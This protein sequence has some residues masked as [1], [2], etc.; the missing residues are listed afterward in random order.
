MEFMAHL[1]S[2]IPSPYESLVYYYGIYSS[3]HRGKEKR[4]NADKEELKTKEVQG[5]TGTVDG[6]ITSTW[7]RL[8]R[9]IFEVNPLCCKKCGGEMKIVAFITNTNRIS[10]F[11]IPCSIILIR[12]FCF[13][14]KI[15]RTFC[16][17]F[18]SFCEISSEHNKINKA[19]SD[20]P[21]LS[22]KFFIV[23]FGNKN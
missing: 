21:I 19:G 17:S 16:E 20:I 13:I 12:L 10:F 7:A 5:K 18:L 2:H 1:A 9:R 14:L 23:R 15:A 11:S 6:K 8:I 3:S 22:E 4:E